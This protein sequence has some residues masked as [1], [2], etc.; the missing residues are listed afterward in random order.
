MEKE[1]DQICPRQNAR[2]LLLEVAKRLFSEKGYEAVSTRELAEAAGVNLGAIQYHFGSKAKLFVETVQ[3]MMHGSGC[4]RAHFS[5]EKPIRSK[6]DAAVALCQFIRDFLEYLL[7]P[8]GPQACRLMIREIFTQ[9]STDQEMYEALVSSVVTE[10]MKPLEA[11][12]ISVLGVLR[13]GCAQQE[14]QLFAQSVL[15][16][17]TVYVTHRPFIER[18][19]EGNV[20][21]SPLFDRTVDHICRFSLRGLGCSEPLIEKTIP[22]A[23]EKL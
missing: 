16:Q 15:G 12:L 4:S 18:L 13:E 20:G 9:T 22:K 21:E 17:C 3:L 6:D 23:M 11:T 7:R 19:F 2:E 8:E 1:P 5:L 14:L 10:F